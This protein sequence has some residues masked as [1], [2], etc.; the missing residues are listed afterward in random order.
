MIQCPRC[1]QADQSFRVQAL[2]E[3]GLTVTKTVGRTSMRLHGAHGPQSAYGSV[4]GTSTA[5][6]SLSRSLKPPP[7]PWAARGWSYAIAAAFAVMFVVNMAVGTVAGAAASWAGLA[8]AAWFLTSYRRRHRVV[9]PQWRQRCATWARMFCCRRC[10][11]LFLPSDDSPDH[12]RGRLV[13]RHALRA[14]LSECVE[15]K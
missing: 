11:G 13:E 1:R 8:A 15:G 10:D 6:T 14:F 12:V 4:R 3:S 2:Y 7:R 9:Y 5:Q